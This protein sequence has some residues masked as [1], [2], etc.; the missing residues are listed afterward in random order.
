[1]DWSKKIDF[2][3]LFNGR[4]IRKEK[5]REQLEHQAI[6][7]AEYEAA[8]TLERE[9]A[10]IQCEQ[11]NHRWSAWSQFTENWHKTDT[12]GV[13]IG[14]SDYTRHGQ[15]RLCKVCSYKEKGYIKKNGN[16]EAEEPEKPIKQEKDK[17]YDYY[18]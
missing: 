9:A 11:G 7:S 8:A 12:Q 4:K 3:A 14:G 6:K 15:Q 2:N 13:G 16:I 10:Q 18:G 17:G 1:M 5:L